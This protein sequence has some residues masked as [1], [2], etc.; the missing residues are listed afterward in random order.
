MAMFGRFTERAQRAIY[1]AQEEANELNH[2]YLG[3]E[4]ILLGLVREGEGVAATVLDEMGVDLEDLR[5][6]IIDIIGEGDEPAEFLG[7]TPRTKRVF[8]LSGEEARILGQNYV[9]T[10]HLLLGL[11]RE[12]EG[13]AAAILR[14]LGI[15]LEKARIEV[16]NTINQ[17][18]TMGK[19]AGG[20]SRK[21]TSNTPTLDEYGRDLTVLAS[22]DKIDPVIGRSKE[23]DRVIQILSRRTKNNPVLIGEPG[24]GKTAIAE[25]LAQKILLGEVPELLK[26]KRVVSLDLPSM[27]AG[28]KY[29]G[30]FEE[31]LKK[32][33]EELV[34]AKNVILFIDEMHTIIG[35]GAAEGSI[36]AANILKPSLARGELQAIG[37]TT[38]DEY[39][40]Y[41]E[42]DSALER[43]FQ[44]VMVEEPSEADTL[45]ILEGLRDK[46]EAHHRVKISDEAL[47]AAV[48]LS[49]RYISDR[50]LPDKAIDLIDEAGSR[51][52]LKSVTRP[53]ILNELETKIEDLNQE[54]EEAINTQDYEKA[55]KIRDEEKEI[56]A[57][58]DKRYEE[59][60]QT[61]H[62]SDKE[63]TYDDIA[64]IVSAS[65]GIPVK[66]MSQEESERLLNLENILHE[67]VIGQDQ[68]VKTLANAV[69][70]ARAG[71]KDPNKPIGSFIFVGPTGVGKT[72]LT[73]ALAESLF[74]DEKAVIRLDMSEYMEKHSVSKLVGSPPGYV[75]FEDGGQLTEKV[76]R[77]PYSVILF[78]EIE[79][80]HPDVFNILL[81]LLDDGRL[82]DSKGR[83]VDFKNTVIILTSN[84]GASTL[85][86]Q[87]TLGFSAPNAG[88]AEKQEY[89]KM[90]DKINEELKRTFR[91][92]FLNRIDETIIF[93]PLNKEQIGKI[94]NIMI[95]DLEDRLKGLHINIEVSESAR[96]FISEK[97]FD[98]DDGA[99]PLERAIRNLVENPLSE[100]MLKGNI[101]N[102]DNIEIV[103][104][105]EKI[106]FNKKSE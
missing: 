80:A 101:G 32:V 90:K 20:E 88:E 53:S 45:K 19:Q 4:H 71:L 15:D 6:Q 36:D 105:G 33:M 27:V 30:E 75:G 73:K 98:P 65:T 48:E 84:V 55:A 74:G 9:G 49:S 83:V 31:R 1:L 85:K 2:D 11:I 12:G 46:Y 100:E 102:N 23:I 24:V 22:Q 44:T 3:T 8:E 13:V 40:K 97:G 91:P 76:R 67:R 79:K 81:Q 10:E 5:D 42:K 25:G 103:Y 37:A 99:R 17:N 96:E 61:K 86:K 56:K 39:K 16:I 21:Q 62:T 58:L 54:K 92:E 69:R 78:D 35:A 66:R 14:N 50:Y 59:W 77:K 72:Y 34:N 43:R 18:Y 60:N 38:I 94:V 82:T 93:H 41:I 95:K 26:D 70:R 52:R 68:A 7:L 89:E 29:R 57:L 64:H 47:R 28:A 106:K 104:D 51:L 87:G 63:V